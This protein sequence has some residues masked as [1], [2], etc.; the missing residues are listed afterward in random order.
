MLHVY[1]CVCEGWGVHANRS[2]QVPG[3]TAF[4]FSLFKGAFHGSELNLQQLRDCPSAHS[5]DLTFNP[6]KDTLIGADNQEITLNAPFG[7]ELPS[8]GFD[9]GTYTCLDDLYVGLA[10]TV[11]TE[12]RSG[13]AHIRRIYIQYMEIPCAVW[14][15]PIHVAWAFLV[16]ACMDVCRLFMSRC[17]L[18]PKKQMH[19]SL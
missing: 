13:Y 7:E 10:Q 2:Y 17:Q 16:C 14:A 18:T 5:G 8:S 11:H 12:I 1:L 4:A 19:L 6:M 3:L 9:P 15:N